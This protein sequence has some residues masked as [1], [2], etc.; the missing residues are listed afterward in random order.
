MDEKIKH[1]EKEHRFE[2]T[3]NGLT[4]YIEY[5]ME[6]GSINF[7]HTI[8]PGPLEGQ[9]IGTALVKHALE[10]AKDQHLRIIPS[11]PFVKSYMDHHKKEFETMQGEKS[12]A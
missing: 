6:P 12:N 8:V 7:T 10:Y 9:G 2:L 4:A 5:E 11:C 3:K 1:N